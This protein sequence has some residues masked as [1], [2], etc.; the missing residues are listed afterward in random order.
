MLNPEYHNKKYIE[1][2]YQGFKCRFYGG[3][4]SENPSSKLAKIGAY[5]AWLAGWY[6]LDKKING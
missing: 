3:A 2:Y 6:D 4:E 5:C 1:N